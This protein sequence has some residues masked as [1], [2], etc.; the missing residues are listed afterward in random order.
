MPFG[1]LRPSGLLMPESKERATSRWT[2]QSRASAS[3][4]RK[5]RST[6]TP[7][8]ASMRTRGAAACSSARRC[9]Y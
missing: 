6:P 8:S 2:S 9:G 1:R 3:G 7:A 4:S 5:R